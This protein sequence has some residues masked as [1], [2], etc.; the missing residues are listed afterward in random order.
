MRDLLDQRDTESSDGW[1]ARSLSRLAQ[2]DGLARVI[3]WLCL[4]L[5]VV[6]AIGVVLNELRM[7]GVLRRVRSVRRGRNIRDLHEPKS[8]VPQWSDVQ[9]ARIEDRPR[10][11]LELIVS[12]LVAEGNLPPADGLTVRELVRSAALG[13]GPDGELLLEV[14]L[15]AERIRY[16]GEPASDDS[17]LRI[18]ERGRLLL[19][20]IE[21]RASPLRGRIA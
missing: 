6:M 8:R 2:S 16:S 20:H 3:S 17:V 9:G 15:A 7:A 10:L 14:A 21:A 12:R 1:V 19:G 18:M 4:G 13:S 5:V 11:L